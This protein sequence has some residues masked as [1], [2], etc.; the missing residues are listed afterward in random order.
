M[1]DKKGNNIPVTPLGNNKYSFTM[2][3]TA[4][5]IEAELLPL[6]DI[7]TFTDVPAGQHTLSITMYGSR[8]NTFGQLHNSNRKERYWGNKTWRTTGKN[9]SYAYQLRQVGV[10][11]P[12]ILRTIGK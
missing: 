5:T 6:S 8:I 9:W 10:I 2:P 4:V 1:T 7:V 11:V 3:G 12:P